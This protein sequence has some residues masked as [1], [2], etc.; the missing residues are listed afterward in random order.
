MALTTGH[1]LLLAICKAPATQDDRCA[2]MLK[3]FWL[4]EPATERFQVQLA[5]AARV[6]QR[7]SMKTHLQRTLAIARTGPDHVTRQ[8]ARSYQAELE[9]EG[10]VLELDAES[11]PRRVRFTV[12]EADAEVDGEAVTIARGTQIVLDRAARPQTRIESRGVSQ[13]AGEVLES[14]LGATAYFPLAQ[15]RYGTGEPQPLDGT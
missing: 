9:L 13:L 15:A 8:E 2:E 12:A 7:F 1:S 10:E 14:T 5:R 3:T 11:A 4:P 6:G